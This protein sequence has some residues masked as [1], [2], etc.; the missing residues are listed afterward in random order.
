MI[1]IQNSAVDTAFKESDVT[2]IVIKLMFRP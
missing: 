2:A 1:S